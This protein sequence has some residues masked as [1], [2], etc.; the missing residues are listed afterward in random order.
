MISRHNLAVLAS[1]LAVS[2]A[3]A[4]VIVMKTGERI[5]GTVTRF[6]HGEHSVANSHFVIDVAGEEKNIPLF[7]I[8]TVTF[9][10]EEMAASAGGTRPTAPSARTA[11]GSG[12]ASKDDTHWLS[13]TGK[14]HNSSCRYYKSS[15]GRACKSTDGVPCKMCG[16]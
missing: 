6:E 9:A 8:D 2:T 3:V 13:S 10:R 16:G 15:K 1:W 4:D 14:R 5:S 12:E 7:K 11:S